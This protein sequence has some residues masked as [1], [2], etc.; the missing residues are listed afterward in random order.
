[1]GILRDENVDQIS[2][3]RKRPNALINDSIWKR[4]LLFPDI[5]LVKIFFALEHKEANQLPLG[6]TQL[7]TTIV[8][9][10]FVR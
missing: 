3:S 2:S 1:M 9:T 5:V 7:N 4:R 10:F 8:R 6:G